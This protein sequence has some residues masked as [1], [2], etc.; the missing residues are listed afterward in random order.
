MTRSRRFTSGFTLVE[1]MIS[2]AILA[3]LM[4]GFTQIFGGS[5]RASAQVNGRNELISE[6]QIAQ[7]LIA[8]RLQSAFYIY[9]P[10]TALQMTSSG[11][12]AKNTVR[13]GAGYVWTV[14]TDPIVAMIVPPKVK[15]QCPTSSAG[16]GSEDACFS[17]Y[18]YYPV[19]RSALIADAPAS[20]PDP[21]P[22]NANAW[23]LME[24]KANLL[25]GVL[26]GDPTKPTDCTGITT[27][28]KSGPDLLSCPPNP[29]TVRTNG[30]AVQ[31]NIKSQ[32]ARMLI[33]YV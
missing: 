12:M 10:S 4:L 2:T 33:D 30:N 11:V 28:T 19:L 27:G 9:P 16:P 31:P 25:D 29:E 6:G 17:F 8:S 22:N 32:P 26:R 18:A 7:Q 13:A 20:A 15:A 3:V 5:L 21:D 14:N 1:M 24:Y 23:V